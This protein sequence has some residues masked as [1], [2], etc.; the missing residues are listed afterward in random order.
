[1]T[2]DYRVY[3]KTKRK[4]LD[5]IDR[6]YFDTSIEALMPGASD[7]MLQRPLAARQGSSREHTALGTQLRQAATDGH[8]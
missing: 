3:D 1:M 5:A 7:C 4:L 8:K 2:P 6:Q